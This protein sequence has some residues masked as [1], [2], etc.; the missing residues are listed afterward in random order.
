M[1]DVEKTPNKPNYPAA[2]EFPLI[3]EDCKFK[4]LEFT[5]SKEEGVD[6][7]NILNGIIMSK[8]MEMTL[9]V[10]CLCVMKGWAQKSIGLEEQTMIKEA[11]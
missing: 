4:G 10:N 5:M 8:V 9:Y 2:P 7:S 11:I 6:I 3:L 1:L